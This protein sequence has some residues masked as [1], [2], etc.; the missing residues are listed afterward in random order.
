MQQMKEHGKKKHTH[1]KPNSNT[2]FRKHRAKDT[3]LFMDKFTIKVLRQYERQPLLSQEG[4]K[5]T[6]IGPGWL[7]TLM[8][9][10]V[11]EVSKL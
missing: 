6:P 4:E 7:L 5:L 11:S 1:T 8:T 10:T 9:S 2:P 3:S